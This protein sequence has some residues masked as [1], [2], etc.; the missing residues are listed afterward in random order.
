MLIL[1]VN[2]FS[3]SLN[4]IILQPAFLKYAKSL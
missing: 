3:K 1:F 4:S 2:Y